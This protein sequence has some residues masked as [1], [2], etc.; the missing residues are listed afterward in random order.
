MPDFISTYAGDTLWA[1]MIFWIFCVV[2]HQ[3]PTGK[4][5]LY[6]LL[7]SFTIEFSQFYHEPWIDEIRHTKLGALVLGY[8]FKFTDLVCYVSGI[9]IGAC[10]DRI[11]NHC[12]SF[13]P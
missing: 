1:L 6:A 8:A 10:I 12:R 7:F 9:F 2:F 5:I 3:Q 11:I 4:I 13:D